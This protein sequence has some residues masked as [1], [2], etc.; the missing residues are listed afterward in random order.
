[1][2]ATTGPVC[3]GTSGE[4]AGEPA[5]EPML[6]MLV[7]E[8]LAHTK[9][10]L[11]NICRHAAT[12]EDLLKLS[13]LNKVFHEVAL[14]EHVWD[15]LYERDFPH[16][17]R[18]LAVRQGVGASG[19]Q[20]TGS[21]PSLLLS[22][23]LLSSSPYVPWYTEYRKRWH[24][25]RCWETGNLAR[26]T[27][28]ILSGHMGCVFGACFLKAP[29]TPGT[30]CTGANIEGE[31]STGNGQCGEIK[32]WLPSRG[33]TIQQIVRDFGEETEL[34]ARCGGDGDGD[35]LEGMDVETITRQEIA[36][37]VRVPCGMFVD[38]RADRL[39]P[40]SCNN[41]TRRVCSVCISCRGRRRLRAP[42]S[43]AVCTS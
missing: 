40:V 13:A 25:E 20:G 24:T 9:S 30:I 21:S 17:H 4:P 15:R 39:T 42:R 14:S 31:H 7:T 36:R 2:A 41:N 3:G 16:D 43:R 35:V 6:S 37:A 26:K 10:A 1:M 22:S 23:S 28:V 19:G 29:F 33:T 27:P 5:G 8:E 38:F 32:M 11:A 18:R 12:K 34:G